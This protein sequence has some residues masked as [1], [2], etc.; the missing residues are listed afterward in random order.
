D[1]TYR[2]SAIHDRLLQTYRI[3]LNTID[4]STIVLNEDEYANLDTI[5]MQTSSRVESMGVVNTMAVEEY[6]TLRE[7]YEFLTSQRNDLEEARTSLLEA[8]RKINRTTKKLFLDVFGHVKK[9]FNDY[10][11]VLFKGG[12]AELILLDGDN[13]LESGIDIFVRPP[14]K[15]L[16]NI[17][18]LSGGEKA[19][20]AIALLFAVF[21]VK[22][23]PYCVLDEVDAPLDEANID[24]FLEV[25]KDFLVTTQFL[26]VTHNRKTITMA[27]TLFGITMEEAGISKVVSVK[28]GEESKFID[29]EAK[30]ADERD[31]IYKPKKKYNVDKIT[32]LVGAKDPGS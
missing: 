6:E 20:T 27:D 22:P 11:K 32:E 18:L 8:I 26:I 30:S 24:R 10:Y 25:L 12:H 17:S 28:L 14:G 2:E 7:R 21:K 3:E 15:K 31:T 9:Y 23:S 29:D 1:H 16:Q 4:R 13:P 5:I 19:L